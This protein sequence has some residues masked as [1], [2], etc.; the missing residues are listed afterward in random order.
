MLAS[1]PWQTSLLHVLCCPQFLVLQPEWACEIRSQIMC[2]LHSKPWNGSISFKAKANS[3]QSLTGPC[4]IW[5]LTPP[6]PSSC[7]PTHSAPSSLVSFSG[8]K[9]APIYLRS[10]CSSSF[11]LSDLPPTSVWLIP[12]LLMSHLPKETQI[13][14]RYCKPPYLLCLFSLQQL[15]HNLTFLIVCWLDLPFNI[16]LRSSLSL[17]RLACCL[18]L[19]CSLRCPRS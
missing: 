1:F 12:L 16:C 15:Y 13:S 10:R 14:T 5:A 7:T 8:T 3:I 17:M 4:L 2:L 6:S 18:F 19:F 11:C 9:Y